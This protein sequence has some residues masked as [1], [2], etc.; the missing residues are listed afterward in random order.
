MGYQ[1]VAHYKPFATEKK[2]KVKVEN[3]TER[4]RPQR[5]SC[6]DEPRNLKNVAAEPK[7]ILHR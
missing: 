1:N 5:A 7:K 4:R 6:N 2:T 3:V